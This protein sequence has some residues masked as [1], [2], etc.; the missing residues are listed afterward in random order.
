[1]QKILSICLLISFSSF[2]G[3]LM[4]ADKCDYINA[5][6]ANSQDSFIVQFSD[7]SQYSVEDNYNLRTMIS[8]AAA[9]R[10][11]VCVWIRNMSS[12]YQAQ[13]NYN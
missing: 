10:A 7:G 4:T 13:A 12:I 5:I 1:M 3:G 9:G 11:R 6:S 2:A 8:S